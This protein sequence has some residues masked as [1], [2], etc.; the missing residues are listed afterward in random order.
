[1][2]LVPAIHHRCGQAKSAVYVSWSGAGVR[3]PGWVDGEL[4]GAA[5]QG[6]VGDVVVQATRYL[7]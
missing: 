5:G 3:R 4:S 1:M 7:V 6:A 2:P